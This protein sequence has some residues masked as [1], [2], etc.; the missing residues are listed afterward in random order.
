MNAKINVAMKVES[1]EEAQKILN[2]ILV[3]MKKKGA[4][5]D[6]SFEIMTDKGTVTERC[7][8]SGGNIIA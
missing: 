1:I 3:K 5:T 8:L 2:D 7:I 4:I 6:Y